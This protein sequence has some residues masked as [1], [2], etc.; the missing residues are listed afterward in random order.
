MQSLSKYNRAI[1][2]LL[3][4]IDLFNKYA[5]IV[6]LKDKRGITIFNPFQKEE[7]QIKYG[8]IRVVNFT[9]IFLKDI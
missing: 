8:L 5:W 1:K 9:I 3:R 2:S 7:N 4:T 6:T